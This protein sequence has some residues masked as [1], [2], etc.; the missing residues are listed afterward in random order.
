MQLRNFTKLNKRFLELL[1][2]W[3]QHNKQTE[4]QWIHGYFVNLDSCGK[5]QIGEW[6]QL[7]IW[8]AAKSFWAYLLTLMD[9]CQNV[10]H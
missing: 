6:R 10:D 2:T 4:Q 3:Q 1:T 9:I 7:P 8:G 5:I